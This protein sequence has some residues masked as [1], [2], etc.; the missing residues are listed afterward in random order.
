APAPRPAADEVEAE[1]ERA[2]LPRPPETEAW[3]LRVVL[4]AD[5]FVEWIAAHLQLE[6]LTHA[7]VRQ[8]VEARLQAG[9]SDTWPGVAAWLSQNENPDW[10]RLVTETLADNR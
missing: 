7:A 4:E 5:E 9:V 2:P 6:W 10:Q 8:I 3:L 1:T